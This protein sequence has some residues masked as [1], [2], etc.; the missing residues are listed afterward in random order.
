MIRQ[1]EHFPTESA[2]LLQNAEAA[3]RQRLPRRAA[4]AVFKFFASVKLAVIVLLTLMVVLAAG[5]FVESY[6]GTDAARILIYQSPWF[7]LVLVILGMNLAAA[8]LDRL[9]WQKKHSGFVITHLGIILILVGSLMTQ[10][11]MIDGQ[12]VIAE[13]E[14]ASKIA[15]AGAPL[16][17]LFSEDLNRDW[18]FELKKE[19]FAWH[20]RRQIGK[21]PL[22]FSLHL[23]ADYPKARM[24]EEIEACADGPAAIQVSLHNSFVNE[25]RWLIENDP[26]LGEIQ[27]GPAKLKFAGELLKDT[28]AAAPAPDTG[29]L[30]F[31]FEKSRINI[32]LAAN[33]KLPAKFTLNG[34]PYQATLERLLKH[35]VVQGAQLMEDKASAGDPPKNPAAELTLEGD[36]LR[37]RHTVFA[38]FPDFPTL[39]G[40]KPSAAGVRIFYRLPDSSGP[41]A[42]SHELR[43]VRQAPSEENPSGLVYQI[44]TGEQIKN[45]NVRL[46]EEVSTGWMNLTFRADRFYPH[47]KIKKNFTPEPGLSTSE[48]VFPAIKVEL[49][50]DGERREVWLRE[51][52]REKIKLGAGEFHLVYGQKQIP[53]GF[54]LELK[55]FRIENYP[56]T[57]NPASFE[58]D[59]KLK[60]DAHGVVKETTISMNKPLAYRGFH[61]YQSG[62]SLQ[63]GQPETS[64]F[65]VGRD[66]GVPVKYLGAIIVVGG[67]ITMFYTRRFSLHSGKLP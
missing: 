21:E 40:M 23:I 36:G 63:E 34:T 15:L 4:Y 58:S 65:S 44:K 2:C 62:Y 25:K 48:N 32:P 46:S 8:A 35:A 59:V 38:K 42:K 16:L 54:R 6:H 24:T 61:I 66:P 47:A 37:E 67:I 55:D 56:G 31:Q 41:M 28:P 27:V 50:K 53:A 39:H 33:L 57:N 18:L 19:P 29:Y 26:A 52:A 9:P 1:S 60:D 49:E 17:Y 22:P 13:G 3:P 64:I 14:T 10:R 20:G 12:M 51:A 5:T 45:G 30:E 7:A 43:F 11:M